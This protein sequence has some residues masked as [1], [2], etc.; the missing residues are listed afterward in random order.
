VKGLAR[1]RVANARRESS[2]R[3][4]LADTIGRREQQDPET[5]VR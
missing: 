4:K 5:Q 1:R 3:V 2:G